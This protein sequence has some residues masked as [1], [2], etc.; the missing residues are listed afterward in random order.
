MRGSQVRFVQIHFED[1]DKHVVFGW[2]PLLRGVATSKTH[3][4]W[5]EPEKS[6]IIP[7]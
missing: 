1:G 4:N 6:S 7:V 3:Q 5:C 2:G